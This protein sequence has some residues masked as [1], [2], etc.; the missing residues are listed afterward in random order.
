MQTTV[1]ADPAA[2]SGAAWETRVKLAACYRLMAHFGVADLTYN[3]LSARHPERLDAF[4]IKGEH[5]LFEEVTAS[6]LLLYDLDGKR[7]EDAGDQVSR[8]GL[9]IHA[10]V[11]AVRPDVNAVF[12]THTVANMAVASQRRGLLPLTQHAMSFYGRIAYHDFGGFEFDVAGRTRLAADL[13]EHFVALLRNHGALVCGRCIP[14][15]F[16]LHHFLEMAC[17]AQV[18]ALSGGADD[19]VVPDH[20][21]AEHGARQFNASIGP[22]DEHFR[23][24]PA[25][26]RLAY[27]LDPAF[28]T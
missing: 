22:R 18:A 28:A 24:W 23:D 7:L 26:M 10:G 21:V 20:D 14:E 2:R 15:A 3:H 11:L 25:L 12:H 6:S 17:R 19:L 8:G 9:V 5:Q 16:V 1:L 13:G 27:R 4:F